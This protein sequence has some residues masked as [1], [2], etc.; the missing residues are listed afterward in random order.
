MG[1]IFENEANFSEISEE[2]ELTKDRVLKIDKV[3]Q[4]AFI[5]VNEEGSTAHVV[6]GE[7]LLNFSFLHLTEFIFLLSATSANLLKVSADN[8]S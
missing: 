4:K 3:K 8:F 6:T 2:M 5:E 1:N 7:F